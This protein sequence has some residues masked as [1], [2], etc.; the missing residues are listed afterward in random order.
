MNRRDMQDRNSP[1]A[2]IDV[3]FAASSPEIQTAIRNYK[4]FWT[5]LSDADRTRLVKVHKLLKQFA[6]RGASL[7]SDTAAELL[8]EKAIQQAQVDSELFDKWWTVL[9]PVLSYG[10]S[11]EIA[12][13]LVWAKIAPGLVRDDPLGEARLAATD[14][15]FSADRIYEQ[16]RHGNERFFIELGKCLSGE[17]KRDLVDAVDN[18]I[19]RILSSRPSTSAKEAVQILRTKS[20]QITE[21]N[22]RVRKQR[23]KAAIRAGREEYDQSQ[24]A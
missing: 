5:T 23:L 1:S 7:S 15:R 12:T 11:Y 4:Q 17:I 6:K 9:T 14:L 18:Q 24:R 13:S 20:F 16:A 22:F 3:Q 8:I 10:I 21:E 19:L 2:S